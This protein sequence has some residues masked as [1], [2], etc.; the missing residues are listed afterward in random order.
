MEAAEPHA[1]AWPMCGPSTHPGQGTRELVDELAD[2]TMR[3]TTVPAHMPKSHQAH[4]EWSPAQSSN[5]QLSLT[6][7]RLRTPSPETN[8]Q[9]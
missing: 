8:R 4:L 7:R 3:H 6:M 2:R 9:K 1:A 5:V